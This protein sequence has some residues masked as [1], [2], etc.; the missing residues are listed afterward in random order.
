MSDTASSIV[1]SIDVMCA[2]A[3]GALEPC[4]GGRVPLRYRL[5]GRFCSWLPLLSQVFVH[6]CA[7]VLEA[8]L[9]CI[10]RAWGS[11]SACACT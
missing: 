7:S 10:K 9:T 2:Q 3:Q 1:L 4:S 6:S 5:T 8:L 11:A